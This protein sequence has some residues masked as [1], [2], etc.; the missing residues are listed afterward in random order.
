VLYYRL[1][2][3]F[4]GI[5][6]EG[7]PVLRRKGNGE[8]RAIMQLGAYVLGVEEA[9]DASGQMK[10]LL[11]DCLNSGTSCLLADLIIDVS[12]FRG[13]IRKAM[14]GDVLVSYE[15]VIEFRGTVSERAIS[16][17]T[18]AIFDE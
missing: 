12:G 1:R 7:N 2:W 17:A 5:I 6:S 13:S 14:L 9:G 4:D 10:V 8:G 3:L 15:V 16:D 11:S 18:L